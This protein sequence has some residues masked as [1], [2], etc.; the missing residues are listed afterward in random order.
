[1]RKKNKRNPLKM[2]NITQKWLSV[3]VPFTR[4]YSCRLT[5]SR[6]ANLTSIPQQ[7]VTRYLNR[8]ASANIL[9]YE[10][11]GRNKY[12][13][14]TDRTASR[15][16]MGM[17]EAYKALEFLLSKKKAAV[18]IEELAG[19]CEALLVFGSYSGGT[20]TGTSDLDTLILGKHDKE[21]IRR[22]KRHS[23]IQIN[24]HYAGF[25]EIKRLILGKN[26][27]ALEIMENHII[28]GDI[29][30]VVKIFFEMKVRK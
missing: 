14:F 18:I 20:E 21:E 25:S 4:D 26:T 6:T 23:P 28:F 13:F 29:F 10:S 12:F 11:D 9:S 27:L 17:T 2:G 3:L 7:T 16:A 5:A 24:E 8:L 19:Q 30:R 15:I 22:I 1:M